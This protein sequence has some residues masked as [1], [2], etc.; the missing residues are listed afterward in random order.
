[1]AK[2]VVSG[3]PAQGMTHFYSAWA[4]PARVPRRA[5]AVVLARPT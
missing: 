5:W 3:G 1:M 4:S 2:W